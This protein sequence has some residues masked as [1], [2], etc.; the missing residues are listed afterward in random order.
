VR[1]AIAAL[2]FLG[3]ATVTAAE[4]AGAAP[5]LRPL[6]ASG[7]YHAVTP[8]RVLD[9]RSG[10]G[11]PMAKVGPGVTI[12]VQI[13]GRAG[14]PSSGAIAVVVN[15][16]ATNPTSAG[17]LTLFPTGEA[18]PDV[19]NLNFEAGDS[20]PNLATV[21]LGAG[22]RVSVHNALG[23]TDVLADVVGW[24]DDGTTATA[25]GWFNP[26]TPARI[27]DTRPGNPIATRTSLDVDVTGVGGVPD[28]GVSAV[29]VNVTATNATAAGYL[30]VHRREAGFPLTSNVNFVPGR[31]VANLAIVDV[32]P[33]TGMISI[34]NH[35]GTVDVVVDV[36]G[37]Y[38]TNGAVGSVFRAVTPARVFDT[39]PFEGLGAGFTYLHVL[40]GRGPIPLTGATAVVMNVTATNQTFPGYLTIYPDDRPR[41]DTSTI[42]WHA[43]RTV[44]N[45]TMQR[46]P[47][48]SSYTAIH[49]APTQFG[50][51]DLIFDVTG[52][53]VAGS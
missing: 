48:G 42:N 17:Y 28:G 29:A 43:G 22:G 18:L 52:Y 9:T 41:P 44:A 11:A 50:L 46:L 26:L 34:Q 15:L 36:V 27:V 4:T 8:E 53:F 2:A 45:L 25:G 40:F 20:V 14:V 24:Y 12:D 37:W 13:A 33:A 23:S 30:T 16:T 31:D 7:G 5:D 47:T 35:F 19:S 39:R 10:V 3:S 51:M 49:V 6:A 38:D 1:T 32:D 21:K